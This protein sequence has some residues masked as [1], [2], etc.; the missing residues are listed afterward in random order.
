MNVAAVCQCCVDRGR[1]GRKKEPQ[2]ADKHRIRTVALST[3]SSG[4]CALLMTL[5]V[6]INVKNSIK[7]I[8][9]LISQMYTSVIVA[10]FCF[11]F[12]FSCL[13]TVEPFGV[14]HAKVCLPPPCGNVGFS[15]VTPAF[16][17]LPELKPF[18]FLF[19]NIL[20][21]HIDSSLKLIIFHI[22]KLC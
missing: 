7:N 22:K 16:V 14:K 21:T 5:N 1:E 19:Q 13:M 15:S 17:F 8:Y 12:F 10:R 11:S 4:G 18:S 9:L 2:T 3:K 6:N 20:N